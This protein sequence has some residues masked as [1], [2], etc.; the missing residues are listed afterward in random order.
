MILSATG[1]G[2]KL[3][4]GGMKISNNILKGRDLL[5]ACIFKS[6]YICYQ[7]VNDADTL[8]KY[9]LFSKTIKKTYIGILY[10]NESG[11][12]CLLI[13]DKKI[14][15]IKKISIDINHVSMEFWGYNIRV[16]LKIRDAI[17][18]TL[19][20]VS[21]EDLSVCINQFL[22]EITPTTSEIDFENTK[23]II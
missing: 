9:D 13:D 16:Y 11:D 5:S 7:L 14:I 8:Y 3:Y 15:V 23:F 12:L 21:L 6:R 18:Q 17:E 10:L 4:R 2:V 1:D 20:Y 19:A 22:C